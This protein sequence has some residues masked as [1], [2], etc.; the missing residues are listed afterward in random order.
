MSNPVNE[1][2]FHSVFRQ[3][4]QYL[5]PLC[6][7]AEKALV[8]IYIPT[9]LILTESEPQDGEKKR[10]TLVGEESYDYI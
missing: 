5:S 4:H 8:S 10:D 2:V 3:S 1:D 7:G 9:S 6:C